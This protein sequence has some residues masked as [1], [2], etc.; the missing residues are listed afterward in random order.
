MDSK[1]VA[2]AET[3]LELVAICPYCGHSQ[4]VSA[5]KKKSCCDTC[6]GEFIYATGCNEYENIQ[7]KARLDG[8]YVRE[9]I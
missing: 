7:N 9:I 8:Y 4:S 6:L 3:Y 1:E 2:N 5:S